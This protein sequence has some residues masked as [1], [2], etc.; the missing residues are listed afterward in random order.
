LDLK[1]LRR[2]IDMAVGALARRLATAGQPSAK[3][4]EAQTALSR[5]AAEIDN[6]CDPAEVGPCGPTMLLPLA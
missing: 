1:K 4:D 6:M 3:L 2:E 5:W